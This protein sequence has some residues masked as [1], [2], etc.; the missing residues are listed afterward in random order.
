[1]KRSSVAVAGAVSA[2]CDE[3]VKVWDLGT[4]AR[5]AAH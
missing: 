2:G 4:G 5:I 1:M 3:V